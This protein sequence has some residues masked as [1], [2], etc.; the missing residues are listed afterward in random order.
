MTAEA[1]SVALVSFVIPAYNCARYLPEAVESALYQTWPNIEVVV[2]NDGS[3]D[4]TDD[5]VRPYLDRIVYLKQENRGLSA[6]RNAG[7]RASRGDF[8][9]FLDAD[10]AVLPGKIAIQMA[11]FAAEPDLGVVISGY[12]DVEEDGRTEILR[13]MKYW[14]RDGLDRLLKHE[15]FPVHS[16]LVRRSVLEES[17]LFPEAIDTAESQEDWQLWL[18]MGLRGVQFAAVSDVL[19]AYR[20]R[21]AAISSRPLKHLD[22]ARRVVSWLRTH[23]LA[24][25]AGDRVERLAAI[26]EGERVAKAM[27]LHSVGLAKEVL[28]AA[29]ARNP[30]YWADPSSWIVLFSR[31]LSLR[32]GA[33][34]AGRLDAA[35]FA[36]RVA[37][38]L[39]A[40]ALGCPNSAA[41]VRACAALLLAESRLAYGEPGNR[42]RLGCVAGAVRIDPGV[43]FRSETK[44]D[45]LRGVLGQ[46]L[47][48]VA[49][50]CFA[51]SSKENGP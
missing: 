7:F 33:A 10:D 20:H 26:V 24:P 40:A 51:R 9:C 31:L 6:A 8:L 34:A 4:D 38:P 1:V 50:A 45:V 32:E 21:T 28:R 13:V 37:A 36:A 41:G 49:R 5:V 14:N 48:S 22:G 15:S 47:V 29:V 11:R 30:G 2:V 12:V 16:A 3:P 44:K 18:D 35:V 42:R 43:L 39:R 25:K 17:C 27:Q 19:C 23:P 46:W